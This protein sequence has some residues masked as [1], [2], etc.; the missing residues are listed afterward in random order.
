[1]NQPILPYPQMYIG[2]KACSALPGVFLTDVFFLNCVLPKYKAWLDQ[3]L[4]ICHPL[5]SVLTGISYNDS[6]GHIFFFIAALLA[7]GKYNMLMSKF[8]A[9]YFNLLFHDRAI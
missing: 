8:F 1:M 6:P 4:M 7:G 5:W 9:W 3:T 2:V